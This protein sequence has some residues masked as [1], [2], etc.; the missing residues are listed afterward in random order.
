M[1]TSLHP[2]GDP[3]AKLGYSDVLP[4]ELQVLEELRLQTLFALRPLRKDR[5]Q[6]F[7]MVGG[8]CFRGI[9]RVPSQTSRFSLSQ[10]EN[11]GRAKHFFH[12]I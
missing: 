3:P 12:G 4:E 6:E 10:E 11:A 8:G 2:A 7:N 9:G 1:L 5:L